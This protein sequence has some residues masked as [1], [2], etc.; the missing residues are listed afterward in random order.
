M[1]FSDRR[2]F[3]KSNIKPGSFIMEVGNTSSFS[4]KF[5]VDFLLKLKAEV[6]FRNFQVFY[7][8][9]YF[10]YSHL[11]LQITLLFNM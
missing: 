5:L 4:I 9:L 10:F 11:H 3:H 6:A 1:L 7:L 8:L 2:A